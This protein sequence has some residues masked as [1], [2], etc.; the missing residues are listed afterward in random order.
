MKG[1]LFNILEKFVIDKIGYDFWEAVL[2]ENGLKDHI[3]VFTKTYDD[4]I[5]F[6]LLHRVKKHL[7]LPQEKV[8]EELGSYSFKVYKNKLPHI[9]NYL[10]RPEEIFFSFDGPMA[11][12]LEKIYEGAKFPSVKVQTNLDG[13]LLIFYKSSRNMFDFFIGIIKEIGA[14]YNLECDIRECKQIIDEEPHYFVR[15]AYLPPKIAS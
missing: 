1:L 2:E 6:P 4:E 11:R 10:T 5:F 8:L 3:F 9:F 12:E 15:L 7:N 13:E 14:K